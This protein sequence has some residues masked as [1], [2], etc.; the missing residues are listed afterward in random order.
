MRKGRVRF[1]VKDFLDVAGE[2]LSRSTRVKDF[3]DL[4]FTVWE[5]GTEF[6]SPETKSARFGWT[7][8]NFSIDMEVKG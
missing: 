4:Y 6:G 8:N 3:D 1:N 2:Y 5:I 7:F